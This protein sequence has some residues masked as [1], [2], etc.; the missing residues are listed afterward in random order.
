MNLADYQREFLRSARYRATPPELEHNVAGAGTLTSREALDVYRKMYWFRLVDA[1][2]SLFPR[3]AKWM[4]RRRFTESVCA[5]LAERPSQVPVIERL[6]RPYADF[7]RGHA[8]PS[9]DA[10]LADLEATGIESLLAADADGTIFDVSGTQA[11][12][13]ASTRLHAVPSLHLRRTYP[14]ALAA[15]KR[16]EPDDNLTDDGEGASI[17]ASSPVAASDASCDVLFVRCGYAVRHLAIDPVEASIFQRARCE[18]VV[19]GDLLGALAG[20]DA[21]P[22]QAFLRFSCFLEHQCFFSR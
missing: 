14:R 9:L 8:A 3:T 4:G 11:K 12:D 22:S 16:I 6:A 2:F 19:V 1:H 21:D 7:L 5:C 15:Y 18:G 20:P 17:I 13:F 10:E